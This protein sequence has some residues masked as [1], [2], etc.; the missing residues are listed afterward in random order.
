MNITVIGSGYVGLV[1]GVCLASKGHSVR[2][3]DI[4]QEVVDTLNSGVPTIY[5]KGLPELL[6]R[7]VSEKLFHARKMSEESL[8][9][10][11]TILLTVGTP[12][13]NGRIDLSYIK[14]ACET[15]GAHIRKTPNFVSVIVKSTVLPSTTDTFV[16][17]I[18]EETSGKKLGE[19]GLGMNPEFL[20]EGEAIEDFMEPDRIVF[21]YEDPKTLSRLEEMYKRWDVLKIKVNTRTAEMIK[22]VNNSLLA[23]QISAINEFAN[24]AARVGNIDMSDVIQGFSS[25]KRWSP[26]VEGK[27]V[28]P[29]IL[30]Y[31]IPGCGF[32]G[33]CFPKDVQALRSLA[34]DAGVQPRVLQAVLDVNERQPHEVIELLK[35][36]NKSLKGMKVLVLGLAFKPGTDDIRESAS[37]QIIQDL[38]AAGCEVAAHDPIASDIVSKKYPEF[39]VNYVKDWQKSVSEADSIIVATAWND[40]RQLAEMQK[41]LTGKTLLDA[42]KLFK[43]SQFPASQYLTIGYR[44]LGQRAQL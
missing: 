40:Y 41:P 13:E 29:E 34:Q 8:S 32:G 12:S 16:R 24:V 11:D 31:L 10:S 18:L 43:S 25:D 14:A 6:S 36:T 28:S 44:S 15:I 4:R 26:I 27:R 1:S 2:C 21:G 19:F 9:F 33:S 5:E 3:L 38:L 39:K 17:K 30:K 35:S 22:Y 37:L 7:V 42:R 23:L 20:R